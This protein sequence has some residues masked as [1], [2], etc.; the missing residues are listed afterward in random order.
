M[1]T[2]DQRWNIFRGLVG[3]NDKTIDNIYNSGMI[4]KLSFISPDE[5]REEFYITKEVK[6]FIT[7][8]SSTIHNFI[9]QTFLHNTADRETVLKFF[10]L[11]ASGKDW[12][13]Y[14]SSA[15]LFK[16][17]TYQN[18][19]ISVVKD[20]V[21][22]QDE[23]TS[24]EELMLTNLTN[25]RVNDFFRLKTQLSDTPKEINT[26]QFENFSFEDIQDA[27]VEELSSINL[28]Q[29]E[30]SFYFPPSDVVKSLNLGD[31][32]CDLSRA[33]YEYLLS[34]VPAQNLKYGTN[35]SDGLV[36]SEVNDCV[37]TE[38]FEN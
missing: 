24:I 6:R 38:M 20:K 7:T 17:F 15:D 32:S 23:P 13:D 2:N 18:S 9:G 31:Y 26:E 34:V 11:K 36:G 12:K 37:A 19:L 29:N 35:F 10:D 22:K 5:K 8:G 21:G 14:L 16:F 3:Y 33:Q 27:I 1:F 4:D 30:S 28:T 25:I